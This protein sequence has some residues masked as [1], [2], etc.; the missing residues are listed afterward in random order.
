MKFCSRC[1]EP[2][3]QRIPEGDTKPRYVCDVCE[4]IHYQN[5]RIIAG[6]L[7]IH[8]DKVLLCKRAINP[9]SGMWTIPAGFMENNESISQGALRET[10]E[11]AN[12]NVEILDLYTVFSL[13][14]ISQVY[15]FFRARLTD[16][17]FSAGDET[18]ETRLFDEAEIPWNE[19]AFPV[20]TQTLEY[21]FKDRKTD[22]FPVRT[23]DII[24]ESRQP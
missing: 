2:V 5:P 9:R 24:Y 20:I 6:C 12:A 10:A 7:P 16:L 18:V 8:E 15:M 21:Y 19:L 23:L 3:S 22:S 17:N 4:R 11:E 1:G 14:H 13:P